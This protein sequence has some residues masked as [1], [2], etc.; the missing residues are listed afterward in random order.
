M[1]VQ[2]LLHDRPIICS[3]SEIMSG[4]PVFCG[5]RVPLKTFLDY[6][7]GEEG[8]TEFVTDFPH[9][10]KPAIQVLE[11]LAKVMIDRD[12][13]SSSNAYPAG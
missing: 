8:L 9:L 6:L 13:R 10:E 4:V 2:Q 3:D 11:V 5:T 1:D 12:R 7:E